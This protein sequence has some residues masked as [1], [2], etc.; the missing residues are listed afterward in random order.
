VFAECRSARAHLLLPVIETNSTYGKSVFSRNLG[1]Q[2]WYGRRGKR[3]FD[4]LG[5]VFGVVVLSIPALVVGLILF[6]LE[7][8]PI[9]FK[10]KRVGRGGKVFTIYKFRTMRNATGLGS[11]ITAAGD[12]RITRVGRFLRKSKLDE[13]PQMFNILLGDMSFVGPRP[14]VPGYLDR[15]SGE[16]ALLW[17]LRPGITG[18][19]TLLFRKEEEMLAAIN[20][21]TRFND[22]IIF[23]EK[24]RINLEYLN[25]LSF[26]LDL[27]YIL[28]TIAPGLSKTLRLDQW[29]GLDYQAF[30]LRI[31]ELAKKYS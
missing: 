21:C 5:S 1:S 7:G 2:S 29:L 10:Q 18:P 13:L 31:R 15:L 17:E 16:A 12:V 22:E 14:D 3:L 4:F 26:F 8:R 9:L 28:A 19:A 11:T 27:G 25:C 23:P 24:V 6:L 30:E 20:D